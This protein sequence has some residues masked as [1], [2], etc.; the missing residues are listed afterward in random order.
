[1]KSITPHFFAGKLELKTKQRIA[2]GLYFFLSG[3]CFA[4]WA[5]RIPTI[6]DALQINDAEL[7]SLLFIMPISQLAGLPIS[8]WLAAKFETR[9]PSLIG[10]VLHASSLV[11]IGF[12]NSILLL[13]IA[14]FVFAFFMRIFNIAMNAQAITLQKEYTKRINGAFHGMWSF[15]GIIGVGLTSLMIAL[16][17]NIQDHLSLVGILTMTVGSIAFKYLITGDKS[18][19]G[20][21]LNLHKPDRQTLLL[22]ILV[23]FAAVCE[24]GMFDWSGIYFKEVVKVEIFTAGY[25]IFMTC[26]ALSRFTSDFVI[27]H[28]G[29]K[30]TYLL[31]A[32]LMSA[33]MLLAVL[34]PN[35]YMS[36][37]GFS[38]VGIGTA[39]IFPMTFLLT[40]TSK[41]YTPSVALSIV[42]TYAMV[43][44]LLGPVIIGY[45]AHSLHLRASF[46]FLALTSLA[47]IP[48]SKLYFSKFKAEY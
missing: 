19:T 47:I 24:G 6:K 10:I 37:I 36:M 3:L 1:M 34:F 21:K 31:S 5:S 23:L 4:S 12:S 8:G 38:M 48:I 28:I 14:M 40:G 18:T 39:S 43:G 9:W 32:S 2:I 30:R 13:G 16:K 25:L 22:G 7:G 15:G 42:V 29:M 20:N 41:K 45:I 26:M 11:L 44:V 35:F 17:V 33:G 27:K 46:V